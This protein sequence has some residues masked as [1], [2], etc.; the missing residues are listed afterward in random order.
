MYWSLTM[1]HNSFNG[2]LSLLMD[3][4]YIVCVIHTVYFLD[5]FSLTHFCNKNVTFVY[6]Q[7]HTGRNIPVQSS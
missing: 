3:Y 7:M 1:Y 6:I 4:E 2:E 5:F